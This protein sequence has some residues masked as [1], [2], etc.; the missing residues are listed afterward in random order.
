[1]HSLSRIK[2]LS[3]L[4]SFGLFQFPGDATPVNMGFYRHST[5][6]AQTVGA[7]LRFVIDVGGWEQS[8]FILAPGQSG[9]PFSPP[10]S[11]QTSLW[12]Q[13]RYVRIGNGED[14][15]PSENVL[16]LVPFSARLP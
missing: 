12:R 5:P 6:Y 4:L 16:T 8:G 2:L 15:P 14:G 3:P 9:H 10:Y 11:D 13:G 7:S 1:N